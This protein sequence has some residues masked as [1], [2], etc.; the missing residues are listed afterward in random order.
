MSG[1]NVPRRL[2]RFRRRNVGA[3]KKPERN[4]GI[5]GIPS[6]EEIAEQMLEKKGTVGVQGKGV[7]RGQAAK[8]AAS[9]VKRFRRQHNRLPMRIEYDQI[10]ENIFSLMQKEE[11]K[12][13]ESKEQERRVEREKRKKEQAVRREDRSQ[14]RGKRKQQAE[15]YEAPK[16]TQKTKSGIADL[17]IKDIFGKK[18]G[19]NED[20]SL[21]EGQE[22]GKDEFSLKE[23]EE[24][25]DEEGKCGNCGRKAEMQAYCPEC[26]QAFCEKCAKS[27]RKLGMQ[28][29]MAC[30]NCGTK[31]RK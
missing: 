14:K 2:K 9:E 31:T 12:D 1:E 11:R 27:V 25:P 26:G 13:R 19:K 24:K 18:E 29:E 3:R 5:Q 4:R 23:L 28:T 30:P 8:L 17:E 6:E 20:F 16:E 22:S 7:D 21:L 10:V 15:E